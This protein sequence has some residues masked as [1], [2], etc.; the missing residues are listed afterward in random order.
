M[1]HLHAHV[2]KL[3]QLFVRKLQLLGIG[4]GVSFGI[5]DSTLVS[6]GVVYELLNEDVALLGGAEH[7]GSE[8]VLGDVLSDL[9]VDELADL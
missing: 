1:L 4:Q 9:L 3:G 5:I 6:V 7:A 8:R 2:N